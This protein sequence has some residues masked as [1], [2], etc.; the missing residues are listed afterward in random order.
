M[1]YLDTPP[2]VTI[3][4]AHHLG[5]SQTWRIRLVWDGPN[6]KNASGWSN[7][8]WQVTHRAGD[9]HV[10]IRYGALGS[11]GQRGIERPLGDGLTR[12]RKKLRKA[13]DY[14]TDSAQRKYVADRM[15]EEAHAHAVIPP[16]RPSIATPSWL[17][18]TVDEIMDRSALDGWV[19]VD[20]DV[21]LSHRVAGA[22][23]V[24]LYVDRRGSLWGVSRS[25]SG[26][27]AHASIPAA[28]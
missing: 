28:G 27:F 20:D 26:T 21:D 9:G 13:Y 14:D 19:L 23:R 15:R 22:D 8:Y 2:L 18:I 7:K 6:P 5:V 11:R 3:S 4:E 10:E 24:N 16:A 25:E 12:A 1:T 17:P